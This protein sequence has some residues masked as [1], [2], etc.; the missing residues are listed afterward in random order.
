MKE[1]TLQ[2]QI[3]AEFGSLPWLRLIRCNTGQAWTGNK[4][5]QIRA[6]VTVLVSPG[7]VVIRRAHPIKFGVPGAADING[8]IAPTGQRI[9]IENKS[10]TGRQTKDQEKYQAMIEKMGGIYILAKSIDDVYRGLK[11]KE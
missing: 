1:S 6:H 10:S 9:E 2:K 8:I 5:E 4:V 3:L 7:D 11:I